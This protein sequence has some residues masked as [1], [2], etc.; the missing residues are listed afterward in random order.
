MEEI[1]MAHIIAFVVIIAAKIVKW[2]LLKSRLIFAAL[3]IAIVL[4]FFKDW[5]E[6]NKMLADG[7]GVAIIA[8]V[9]ISWVITLIRYIRNRKSN[10]EMILDWAYERYGE[11]V[12]LTRKT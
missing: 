9:A 7:I 2:G 4:L 11:P 6:S 3:P 1:E 10:K 5:Y 8:G 12:I